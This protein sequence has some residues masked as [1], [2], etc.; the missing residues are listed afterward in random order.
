AAFVRMREC[1]PHLDNSSKAVSLVQTAESAL[2]EQNALLLKIRGMLP[3]AP[4]PRRET[5][6]ANE[7]G[8]CQPTER[9]WTSVLGMELWPRLRRSL[10]VQEVTSVAAERE[11]LAAAFSPTG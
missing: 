7:T 10:P 4:A 1:N 3:L 8:L 11:G 5:V 2:N 9:I 6:T